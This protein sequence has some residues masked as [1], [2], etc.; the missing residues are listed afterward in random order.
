MDKYKIESLESEI[1]ELRHR[2]GFL[3]NIIR[4]TQK[5]LITMMGCPD[6]SSKEYK[7]SCLR[8]LINEFFKDG[9]QA[10]YLL[11]GLNLLKGYENINSVNERRLKY[12]N[13]YLSH[14]KLKGN[15]ADTLRKREDNFISD[16][17]HEL[18]AAHQ[19]D[20]IKK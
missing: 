1:K 19:N 10:D 20:N 5:N 2:R 17:T 6:D 13:D 16:F 18:I 3:T 12:Y 11:L 8:A 4:N 15:I 7:A 9:E 14:E